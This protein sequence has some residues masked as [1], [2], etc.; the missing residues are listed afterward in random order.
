MMTPWYDI[1]QHDMHVQS[2]RQLNAKTN[3]YVG[4]QE[5]HVSP[6]LL[7]SMGNGHFV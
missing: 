7:C 2:L 6:N 4:I 5:S 1:L 3:Q